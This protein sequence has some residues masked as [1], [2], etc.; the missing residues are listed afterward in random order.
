MLT[1]VDGMLVFTLKGLIH[2]SRLTLES[3]ILQEEYS[4]CKHT[5]AR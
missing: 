1:I 3:K 2:V 5:V 4:G